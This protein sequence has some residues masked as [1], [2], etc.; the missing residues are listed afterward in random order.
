MR[1]RW[2][3]M[4]CD[5]V[6]VH[7]HAKEIEAIVYPAILTEL[8]FVNKRFIIWHTRSHFLEDRVANHTQMDSI[9]LTPRGASCRK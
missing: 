6:D 9:H 7:Q 2:L 8:V 4:D 3:L 5:A 1:S